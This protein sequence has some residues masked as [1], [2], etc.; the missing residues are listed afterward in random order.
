MLRV[1]NILPWVCCGLVPTHTLRMF[2]YGVSVILSVYL[3]GFPR[4]LTNRTGRGWLHAFSCLLPTTDF[5]ERL[6]MT[7]STNTW[8][9]CY[10]RRKNVKSL[11]EGKIL[12]KRRGTAIM[13]YV[14]KPLHNVRASLAVVLDEHYCLSVWSCGLPPLQSAHIFCI[15]QNAHQRR[16]HQKKKR[17]K[18]AV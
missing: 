4:T 16:Q 14:P 11:G 2:P 13:V 10:V 17:S 15:K 1:W 18:H 12:R 5:D 3:T 8:M 7:M 9:I 6:S